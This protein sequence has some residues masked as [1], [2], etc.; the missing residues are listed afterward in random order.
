MEAKEYENKFNSNIEANLGAE[1]GST[2]RKTLNAKQDVAVQRLKGRKIVRR[3]MGD[4]RFRFK[5]NAMLYKND[6]YIKG[7]V[8]DISKS[9]VFIEADRTVFKENEKV[10]L[11]IKPDGMSKAYKSI[12]TVMRYTNDPRYPS[13]YGLKFVVPNS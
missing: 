12:A 3:V 4:K 13:G 10:Q 5:A 8:L 6:R 2:L 9:G 11:Y 1:P 7:K